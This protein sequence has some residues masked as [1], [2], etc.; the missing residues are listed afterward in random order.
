MEIDPIQKLKQMKK[1]N[2]CAY[3]GCKNK[4][5]MNVMLPVGELTESG[6]ITFPQEGKNQ[7]IQSSCPLC[8]YHLIFANRGIINLVNQQG[9]VRLFGPFP[10]VE[11]CEVVVEAKEFHKGIQKEMNKSIKKNATNTKKTKQM[12]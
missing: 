7:S 1:L 3:P 8:E 12:P 11:I 10:I 2:R 6:Q 5:I 9:M 4:S